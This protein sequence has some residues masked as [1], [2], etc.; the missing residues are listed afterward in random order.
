MNNNMVLRD[1]TVRLI[2]IPILGV[3]IPILT[4]LITN[5][6]YRSIELVGSYLY[7][8]IVILL[9]WEGNIRLMYFIRERYPWTRGSY[10]KIIIALFF[11]NVIY[12]GLISCL[13]LKVWKI[14]SREP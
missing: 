6:L 10:Y 12:S 11:V 1:R 7:F 3:L 14:W 9:V 5:H 13:L 2:G 8:I 4:G